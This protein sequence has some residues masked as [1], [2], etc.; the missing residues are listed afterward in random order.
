MCSLRVIFFLSVLLSQTLS[1]HHEEDGGEELVTCDQTGPQ[2]CLC[3]VIAA[4]SGG[5]TTFRTCTSVLNM[6][7]SLSYTHTHTHARTH[8]HTHT[9]THTLIT[10]ALRR[11]VALSLFLSQ[12]LREFQSERSRGRSTQTLSRRRFSVSL[13]VTCTLRTYTS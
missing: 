8:T 4:S 13:A 5:T 7:V 9:H 2:P 10:C 12:R 1:C 11:W 3:L 6:S